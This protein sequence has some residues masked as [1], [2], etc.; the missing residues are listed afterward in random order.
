MAVIKKIHIYP[1]KSL[2]A[3][4]LNRATIGRFGL[5]HDR[6]MTL[7]NDQL[8]FISQRTFPQLAKL[9]LKMTDDFLRVQ[10]SFE[11]S[12]KIPLNLQG[13]CQ[14]QQIK[15]WSDLVNASI[16]A[17]SIN[18][19][20]SDLLKSKV[21]LCA[22]T[23]PRYASSKELTP[24]SFVDSFPILVTSIQTLNALNKLAASRFEM[25]RFRANIVIDQLRENV[26]YKI[27]S[28]DCAGIGFKVEQACTRCKVININQE[29]GEKDLKDSSCFKNLR[30]FCAPHKNVFFGIYVSQ[31]KTGII[32]T[33]DRFENVSFQEN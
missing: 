25:S 14:P 24:I 30:S 6:S 8:K 20:F 12:I 21:F 22:H 7:V 27:K 9:K 11:Q 17:K 4:T 10:N 33:S 26:E 13:L 16:M 32:K 2:P 18:E 5:Q 31:Q 28:F 15:V 23:E 29:S 3:I 1:I 19:F